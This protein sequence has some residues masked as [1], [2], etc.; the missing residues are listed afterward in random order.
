MQNAPASPGYRSP[1]AAAFLSFLFPG[2]GQLFTGLPQRALAF[3][4]LPLLA[5]ALLAGVLANPGARNGLLANLASPTVLILVLVLNIALLVYRA[6]AVVDAYRT[7]RA[8]SSVAEAG[9]RRRKK[10]PS[11]Q[12]LSVAGLAAI[13]VVMALGHLAV[14]RYNLL[15]YDL[16]TGITSGSNYTGSA[17]SA[18][19][20]ADRASRGGVPTPSAAPP[21]NGRERLNILLIGTDHRPQLEGHYL[22]DTLILVSIDPETR[23]AAMFSLPRD[24]VRVPLPA[25]WP[26]HN[27]YGGAY[28]D[29]IN[30]LFQRAVSS[31]NL[32]PGDDRSRGY[33]AL[34]GALGELYQT[35]IRY[36]VEVDF[37]GFRT[38][39]DTLGGLTLDVQLPLSDDHYPTDDGRGYLNLYIPAGIQ[40][41]DG[42]EALAY[43]RS[44]NKSNDF[45][46][47]ERQQRVLLSLRQQADIGT[48]LA[49]GRLEALV[50]ALRQ[51]VRTDI[52]GELLPQ[53]IS[54]AQSVD[55]AN[56]RSVVFTPP[57]Y[58]TECVTC[59]SVTPKLEAIRRA[60]RE[61]FAAPAR[62]ASRAKLAREAANIVVLNGSGKEGQA[63]R[64]AQYLGYLGLTARVPAANAGRADRLNYTTTVI[65]VYNGAEARIP[66]TVRVLEE[67]FRVTAR[68]ERDAGIQA[69]VF[70]ITGSQT[71]DL[72]APR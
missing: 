3:A 8:I 53:L 67:T 72:R 51:A 26:A 30:S 33:L 60:V 47:A 34:K 42:A 19:R 11:L 39:I 65:T 45:D 4:A 52:P 6:A 22:T 28:P 10:Q 25:A 7:A 16:I 57:V 63:T 23:R 41:L 46:R 36:Y 37:R 20:A 55:V 5:V 54:L 17:Q 56:A 64:T 43:A 50:A 27:F 48:L 62:E 9:A 29:K 44:R 18:A 66:E 1:F 24:T 59:Y 38:V 49:P 12:P 35:D 69:D 68:R 40:D 31:P 21:W 58:Q 71:P 15:A 61:A 70:V 2:L 32:F 13:L 14:A